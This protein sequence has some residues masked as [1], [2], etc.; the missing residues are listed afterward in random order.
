MSLF[1]QLCEFF[2]QLCE[3]VF[4]SCV[5]FV[6]QL[7][8]FVT[9]GELDA[10]TIQLLWERFARKIPGTTDAD[11]RAALQLLAMTAR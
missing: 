11:S 2:L 10:S 1:F 3:F 4:F 5:M 8:E 6:F 7:C 9:S